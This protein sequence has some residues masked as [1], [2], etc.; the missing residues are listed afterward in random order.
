[1]NV[2]EEFDTRLDSPVVFELL[3]KRVA[4]EESRLEPAH[5]SIAD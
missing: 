5:V 4:K 2:A 1:M 3:Q